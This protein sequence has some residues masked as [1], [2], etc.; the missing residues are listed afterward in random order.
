MKKAKQLQS[1][2]LGRLTQHINIRIEDSRKKEHWC[3]NW[4]R[5]NFAQ[6]SAVMVLYDHVK[7][8]IQCLDNTTTLLKSIQNFVIVG[9]DEESMQGAYLYYDTND[10]KW[11]RSR[12]VTGRSF[13]DRHK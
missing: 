6:M 2:L 1:I 10:E 9:E 8:D 7:E 3:L 11:I 13:L 4:A 5:D 12:K